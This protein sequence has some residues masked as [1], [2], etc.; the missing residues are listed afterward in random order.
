MSGK[1]I[2]N[3]ANAALK[4]DAQ[5]NALNWVAFLRENDF[6]IAWDAQHNGWSVNYKNNRVGSVYILS[7]ENMLA[8]IFTT[9]DFDGGGTVDDDLK[10]FAWAHTVVCPQGCDGTTICDMSQK[11]IRIFG[12]EYENICIS[13]LSMFNPNA[14]DLEYA[15][16]LMLMIKQNRVDK[17][18]E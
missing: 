9:R 7:D 16:K 18:T 5:A 4:G 1:I 3:V 2:E 17:P 13:P 8:I 15:K 11:N 6:L 12:K 10:E 14:K